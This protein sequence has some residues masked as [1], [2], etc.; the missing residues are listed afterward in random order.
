ML[1]DARGQQRE[2]RGTRSVSYNKQ[3]RAVETNGELMCR[4][5]EANTKIEFGHPN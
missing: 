2:R 3:M 5:Q 1:C 4:R